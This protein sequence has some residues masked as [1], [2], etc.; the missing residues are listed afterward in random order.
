MHVCLWNANRL[1]L[2]PGPPTASKMGDQTIVVGQE[3]TFETTVGGFPTPCVKWLVSGR[4]I[5]PDYRYTIHEGVSRH[6]LCIRQCQYTD[7]GVI[8][9][10]ASNV[11]GCKTVSAILLVTSDMELHVC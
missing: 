2:F 1:V 4:E 3:V 6:T 7:T 9:M 8:T 10:A 5:R 11:Y